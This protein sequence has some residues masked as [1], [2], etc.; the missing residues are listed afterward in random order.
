M[1]LRSALARM[2]R[3]LD[4]RRRGRAAGLHLLIS[5][6]VAC[7]AAVLVFGLW[8]PGPFRLLAGGRELFFLV[9]SVDV[10]LG[11]LL[12]FAVF[13]V[14]KGW[15]PLGRDLAVIGLLQTAAL[16]YGLHTVYVARPVA[17]VFEVDLFRLV[18]AN[19]VSLPDL[20]KAPLEFRNL[21]LTGPWLL[22]ARRPNAGAESTDALFK[23]I[24]GTDV[25]LRPLFWQ[26]YEK[27]REA[28]VAKSRPIALLLRHYAKTSPD[29]HTRLADLHADE[30]SAL[31]VPVIAR[32]DWVAVL[33]KTGTVLGYLPFDGFF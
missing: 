32:G 27:S 3:T 5:V 4:L 26:P 17:M 6:A 10:V 30:G 19:D 15:K 22:G 8:Y 31:F 24:D 16:A 33:D 29:L 14:A 11:P 7:L 20:P 21:P 2:P 1:L 28:A 23:G 12:T 25:G 13:D 9:T 18:V